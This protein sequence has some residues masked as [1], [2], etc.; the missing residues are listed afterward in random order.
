MKTEAFGFSKRA[1]KEATL[2]TVEGKNGMSFSVTDYGAAL[3]SIC[4]PDRNGKPVD[5]CLGYTSVEGYENNWGYL[6]AVIGRITNRVGGA[7]FTFQGK[8]YVLDD[9]DG[10]QTLHGG[11]NGLDKRL[12]NYQLLEDINAVA[13]YMT[14]PD[15]DQGIPGEVHICVTYRLTDEG[16]LRISYS[17]VPEQD[18][19]INMTNHTY[20]NLSGHNAGECLD[21]TVWIHADFMNGLKTGISATGE[22]VSVKGTPFDFTEPHKIGERIHDESCPA[23]KICGGYDGNHVL[24]DYDG[25]VRK[26]ACAHADDTGITME[27]WTDQPGMTFYSSNFVDGYTNGKDGMTYQKYAGFCMETQHYPNSPNCPHFPSI[28][29]KKGQAF[30]SETTYVFSAE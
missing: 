25:S 5:V 10:G 3:V 18:T 27:V 21:T 15:G 14:C 19:L 1:G 28:V 7:K 24:N 6:G 12:W 2:I 16:G 8:E 29:Y 11:E 23:L 4:V 13:F 30:F 22:I 20:F 17:A 9:N 26:V